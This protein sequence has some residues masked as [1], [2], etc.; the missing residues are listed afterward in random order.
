[1]SRISNLGVALYETESAWGENVTTYANRVALL[2]RVDVS[3][4]TQEKLDPL[5]V[6]QYRGERT[7]P[8][9]GVKGGSFSIRLWFS[10]HGSST[11]GATAMTTLGNLIANAIGTGA[12]VASS[13]TTLT[14]STDADTWAT[15]ASGTFTP[16]GVCFLG[17][18]GDTDGEGQAYAITSHTGTAMEVKNA[19][20]GAPVNGAVLYSAENIYPDP[21]AAA[22]LTSSRWR[23]LTA[24]LQYDA[25]G[26]FP[27]AIAWDLP[28][29]G[30]PSV[31]ITYGVSWW[32]CVSATFPDST[33][34]DTFPPAPIAAGSLFL[35][36]H[37][38][39]TRAVQTFRAISISHDLGVIV[40]RG[41]GG[42]D[43][44][45]DVIGAVRGMDMLTLSVT[46][47]SEA[48]SA[49]PTIPGNWESDTQFW[50]AMLSLNGAASGKRAAF[51]LRKCYF[52]G[53][54]PVQVEENGLNRLRYDLVACTD[55]AGTNDITRSAY[56]IALG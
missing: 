24:N 32:T 27:T 38:T 31:T 28:V 10:G 42:V 46:V 8:I 19:A 5:R 41:P 34:V 37:A 33:S 18:L 45:Q 11:A 14:G 55:T 22:T 49:T 35:Q 36:N 29:G 53:G 23:L 13:G 56:L 51:Y 2:D 26:C 9:R 21:D 3:G 43:Q 40:Q 7:M 54:H 39:T 17:A 4:L 16:G 44:Y 52:A 50:H 48:A 47:D 30:L 25:H 20:A 15:T 12:V 6:V 1:M